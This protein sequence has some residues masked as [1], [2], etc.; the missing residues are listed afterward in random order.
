MFVCA[1][2]TLFVEWI[3]K[4]SFL[5]VKTASSGSFGRR[6]KRSD[7]YRDSSSPVND[8]E[9][10]CNFCDWRWTGCGEWLSPG[11]VVVKGSVFRSRQRS[12]IYKITN[13]VLRWSVYMLWF[14]CLIDWTSFSD[15]LLLFNEFGLI[16]FFVWTKE[17]K[18]HILYIL[19]YQSKAKKWKTYFNRWKFYTQGH[20]C[21]VEVSYWLKYFFLE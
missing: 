20:K 1:L 16:L 4:T 14:V 9:L 18:T 21:S 8:T 19:V 12:A 17:S 2:L 5:I 11:A 15:L 13:I 6:P 3:N 10:W 7:V